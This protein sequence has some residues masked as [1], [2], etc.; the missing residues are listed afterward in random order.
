MVVLM[1]VEEFCGRFVATACLEYPES[2][3]LPIRDLGEI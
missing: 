2:F 1:Q 3:Q